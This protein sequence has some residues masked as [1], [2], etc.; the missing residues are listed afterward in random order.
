MKNRDD[1]H[2]QLPFDPQ[3]LETRERLLA[4]NHY[5]AVAAMEHA[6]VAS[7]AR[8]SLQLMALGAP[9]D[10][11]RD[12]HQAAL[13]EIEHARTTFS[14]ANLFGQANVG[15]DKLPAAIASID[16]NI[17]AFV[18]ALVLEGCV[19]ETL[20]A[21]EGRESAQHAAWREIAEPLAKIAQDEERHATLAWRTLQWALATFGEQAQQAAT[22]AFVEA[23]AMYSQDPSG[24]ESV[25]SVGVLSGPEL[26]ALRRHVL[27]NVITP[28]AGALGIPIQSPEISMP[29]SC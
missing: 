13:D 3:N 16:S 18:K 29:S 7:F 27:K 23:M 10:L 25:K 8:F 17:D 1:W 24:T 28:C 2:E 26:G 11:V 15:P 5:A 12:A 21:G 6:S 14:L 4:A 22:L 19:G 20:G 9:P